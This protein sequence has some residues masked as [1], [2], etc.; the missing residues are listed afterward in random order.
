MSSATCARYP[1][2]PGELFARAPLIAETGGLD[3]A[4]RSVDRATN[5]HEAE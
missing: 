1:S 3:E 2:T 4:F 5:R